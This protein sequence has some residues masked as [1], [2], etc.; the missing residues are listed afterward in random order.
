[1]TRFD[2]PEGF[3]WSASRHGT[4]S[5][6]ARAYFFRYYGS[7]GKADPPLPPGR[8][9]EA[10]RL[11]HLTS[12]PMW[13]GSRVHGA[14]E[15]I[16][17]AVRRGEEVDVDGEIE[18]MVDGMRR[19]YDASRRD[20]ARLRDDPRRHVR[21]VEHEYGIEVPPDEWRAQVGAAREMVRAFADGGWLDR[22]RSLDPGEVLALE[23]LD[24]WDFEGVPVW[25]RIDAAWRNPD[26]RVTIVDWKT[27][28]RER[29]DNPLQLL[30]YAAYARDRWGVDLGA[31]EVLEVYLR[32]DP[33][34]KACRVDEETVE[35]GRQVIRDSVRSMLEVLP[36]PSRDAAA[37]DRCPPRPGQYR[38]TYCPFRS[39][40]EAGKE[41]VG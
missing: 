38:C 22:F 26:G 4:F 41:F 21:F 18:R 24:R 7:L 8:R 17:K 20:L 28:R 5:D 40:C 1:M 39:L 29:E 35:N 31:L 37:E 11:R 13:I 2:V 6:C 25:V 36:D 15:G 23:D 30:G 16:L 12:V 27:G 34:E 10:W 3:S 32:R 19:D 14:I 33:P 9:R